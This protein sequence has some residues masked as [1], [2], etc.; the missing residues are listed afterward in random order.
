MVI[1]MGI[2]NKLFISK[3]KKRKN[4]IIKNKPELLMHT[5]TVFPDK[6]YIDKVGIKT[7]FL[8][9][10]SEEKINIEGVDCILHTNLMERTIL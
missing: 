3:G 2:F 5:S 7:N 6:I 8:I 4:Q 10:I 9:G 1:N